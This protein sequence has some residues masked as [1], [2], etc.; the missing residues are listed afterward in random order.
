MLTDLKIKQAK[1]TKRAYKLADQRGLYLE[2][3]P[4]GSK[5]WRYKYRTLV[6]GER[7]EKRLALGV[8]PET[9]LSQ[10]R[11]QHAQA[12]QAVKKGKDPSAM[13]RLDKQARHQSESNTF[14]SIGQDWFDSREGTW[15]ETHTDRQRRLFEKDLAPL[16]Q[17][18]IDSITPADILR[19]LKIIEQRGAIESAH[20]ANQIVSQVFR[21]AKVLGFCQQNPAQDLGIALRIPVRRHHAA[22]IDPV[23]LSQVLLGIDEYEGSEVVRTALKLTPLLLVRPGELRRMEWG[24]LDLIE[25][26]WLIPAEKMKRKK[27]HY[28]PLASQVVSLLENLKYHT[29]KGRY[30]FPSHRSFQRPMSENAVLYALRGLGIDKDQAT[31]H[32][33]R[34]TAKTLMEEQ[35]GFRTDLIEHQ[36]SHS[37]RDATGEAY[38]RTKFLPQRRE[39]LQ[40]WADYLDALKSGDRFSISK[41]SILS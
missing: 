29:G 21:R 36:L 18:L 33:F 4:N 13:K 17:M 7:K 20:R 9:T 23:E 25:K 2:V 1:P 24:E 11:E 28:V 31:P 37:V 19:V 12:H 5:Y 10:A 41:V 6:G 3:A 34:A 30:V 8:Y 38:N 15:S 39:M 35:L 32:G 16:H 27:D 14:G 26:E 22:I 40:K